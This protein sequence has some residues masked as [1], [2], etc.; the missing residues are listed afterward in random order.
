M[1]EVTRSYFLSVKYFQN[2]Y[3]NNLEQIRE[4]Y[5]LLYKEHE[6]KIMLNNYI[7]II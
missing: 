4:N 1:K 3:M 5:I 6:R 7:Y 2:T